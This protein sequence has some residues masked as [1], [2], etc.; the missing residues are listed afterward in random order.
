MARRADDMK[1]PG[2]NFCSECGTKLEYRFH[3]MENKEVP[4]CAACGD[5]RFPLFNVACSMI[6]MD[7]DRKKILL[8][9]QYG[10]DKN[11]LVAGYVNLGEDAENTVRREI[12]EE[13]GV[14]VTDVRFNR[15]HYHARTN[16]LMLNFTVVLETEDVQPNKEIDS[17]N[18]YPIEEARREVWQGSLAHQFIEGYL[19][20]GNYDFGRNND[21]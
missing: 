18:W 19:N 17:Y 12:K 10:R 13:L 21:D 16:V 11:I 8:I 9:K 20:G 14:G 2:N 15:T 4:Y 3:M 7:P 5:Y 1:T 6:V